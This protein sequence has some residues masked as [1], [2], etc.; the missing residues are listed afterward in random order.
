MSTVTQPIILTN[1][2][3]IEQEI[4]QLF[5]DMVGRL[6]TEWELKEWAFKLTHG[7]VDI[8][9]LIAELKIEILAIQQAEA[10]V[11]QQGVE[12][13]ALAVSDDEQIVNSLNDAIWS[14]EDRRD[15]LQIV[16]DGVE[17]I[18]LKSQMLTQIG[19]E[20]VIDA[21]SLSSGAAASGGGFSLGGLVAA[22][23]GLGAAAGGGGGSSTTTI[24]KQYPEQS[25]TQPTQSQS[26]TLQ[27]GTQPNSQTP[28]SNGSGSSS[29]ASAVIAGAVACVSCGGGGSSTVTEVVTTPTPSVVQGVAFSGQHSGEW[30]L[31]LENSLTYAWGKPA[32]LTYADFDKDGDTDVMFF[33]SNFTKAVHIPIAVFTNDGNGKFT[34]AENFI[35]NETPYEFV[36]DVIE[37]DFDG[38]G[39]IDYVLLDQGWELD[40]ADM[41]RDSRYFKGA[42]VKYLEQTDSG[43]VMRDL[44]DSTKSFNHTGGQSGDINGDGHLDFVAAN[45]GM[46]NMNFGVYLGNGDG[47]FTLNQSAASNVFD[48][49]SSATIIDIN[50][51]EKVAVGSYRGWQDFPSSINH[52][53]EIFGWN[54]GV[55]VFEQSLPRPFDSTYGRNYGAANMYAQDING[56]G[57]EDLI[58]GW[59]TEADRF[60]GSN[61]G[62]QDGIAAMNNPDNPSAPQIRYG[63]IGF[64]NQLWAVYKQDAD[65]KFALTDVMNG[66]GFGSAVEMRFVDVDKDGDIDMYNN[67][68]GSK[69]ADWH[70]N[71][72]LNDGDGNFFHPEPFDTSNLN[73]NSWENSVAEF[74]DVDG[75][76]DL[77]VTSLNTLFPGDLEQGAQND[78]SFGS[79][80]DT[81]FSDHFVP[82]IGNDPYDTTL[83]LFIA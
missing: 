15:N 12:A 41:T 69:V 13:D 35:Q 2:L 37:G 27:I 17:S 25:S 32:G 45:F 48:Y 3:T 72:F 50:G 4:T 21:P 39:D 40:S 79:G 55:L 74:F 75:D 56:D 64:N 14:Y 51:V 33:P 16:E 46:N 70:K 8:K 1:A 76:G 81:F 6:P 80:V 59:E 71:W 10:N 7:Q 31:D 30:H 54:N 18:D 22:I 67:N 53:I 20:T 73:V 36:R 47:T 62:F 57:R 28:V 24:I 60:D 43:L 77:D 34:Y 52:D 26:E 61:I 66:T 23:G 82:M 9:D 29:A 49:N 65:G 63:E 44:G 68:Y 38:D 83:G 78:R 58:V 5:L 19:T 11:R 42:T